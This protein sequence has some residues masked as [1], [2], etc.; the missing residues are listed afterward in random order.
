MIWTTFINQLT[1]EILCSLQEL[2]ELAAKAYFDSTASNR[3]YWKS[4]MSMELKKLQEH[5]G[6]KID[7]LQNE[8]SLNYSM[9]VSLF[10]LKNLKS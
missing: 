5:Y 9:Q 1:Y 7:E 4:E 10:L 8:M 6:E 3:E 2:R